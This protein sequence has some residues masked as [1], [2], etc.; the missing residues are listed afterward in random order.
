MVRQRARRLTGLR[1]PWTAVLLG[2]LLVGVV[3][4]LWWSVAGPSGRGPQPPTTDAFA[5]RL[6]ELAA[7]RGAVRVLADDPIRKIDGVFVRTWTVELP[8]VQAAESLAG[9]IAAAAGTIPAEATVVETGADGGRR[10]R[11]VLGPET[12]DVRLHVL[13]PATPVPVE[14]ATATPVPSPTPRPTLPPDARGKLSILLDDGGQ[15]LELVPAV[16]ELDPAIA[17]AVLPFLP[18]SAETAMALF[19]AGHEVWLHL[20]M[21][22]GPGASTSPG[23]G[24]VMVG[25]SEVELRT[26]VHAALNSVPHVVG[27]NNHMGS[28]ATADLRTMTWVMQE[29]KARDMR[30]IDSR[31]T[32]RTV[33]E[34]A[35]RAQGVPTGRR[36]VF[37]DNART[38]SAIRAQLEEAV[39]RAR[40]EGEAIAI[41]HLVPVTVEVLGREIPGL[42]SRGVELVRPSD[43]TR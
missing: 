17:V 31:T 24:A 15:S 29:L 14:A 39:Y 18:H 20:P 41:G 23:A 37:L 34:N 9:D 3:A 25:M 26:T 21:E 1:A 42:A 27:V 35:A 19:R 36:H 11:V 6:G 5:A 33:A 8:S 30:F 13:T 7:R 12:F 43:L 40:S 16:T 28:R 38:R 4:A 2:I 10:L 22:A 32:N